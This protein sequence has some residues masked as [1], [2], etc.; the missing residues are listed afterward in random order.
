MLAAAIG[1]VVRGRSARSRALLCRPASVHQRARTPHGPSIQITRIVCPVSGFVQPTAAVCER[2]F[3]LYVCH[4]QL[5]IR[6]E[7]VV[8]TCMNRSVWSVRHSNLHLVH[9]Q[10]RVRSEDNFSWF[11]NRER[12]IGKPT[13]Q[14]K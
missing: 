11:R 6:K 8:D 3:L 13:D 9:K 7:R 12:A 14:F 5:R 2:P 10:F 4:E 1:T